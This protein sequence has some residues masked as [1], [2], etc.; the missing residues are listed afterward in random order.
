MIK[1][2]P[3]LTPAESTCCASRSNLISPCCIKRPIR[4]DLRST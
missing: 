4:L 3:P 2:H 1:E